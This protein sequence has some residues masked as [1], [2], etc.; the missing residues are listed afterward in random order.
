MNSVNRD[1]INYRNAIEHYTRILKEDSLIND[2]EMEDDGRP[3]LSEKDKVKINEK[4]EGL[5]EKR[6]ELLEQEKDLEGLI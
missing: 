4:I 3:R 1:L 2:G 5:T 6:D